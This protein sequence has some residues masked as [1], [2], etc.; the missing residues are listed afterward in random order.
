[1]TTATVPLK[2]EDQ[3]YLNYLLKDVRIAQNKAEVFR[4]AL[5]KLAEYEAIESV[6]R[7]QR[8]IAEGKGLKGDLRELAKRMI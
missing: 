4:I 3:K 2:K 5:R 7:G 8:E 1:M 6:L